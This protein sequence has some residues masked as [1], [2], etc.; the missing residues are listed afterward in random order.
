MPKKVDHTKRKIQIAKAV[1]KVISE[2][3]IEHVTVRKVA[4]TAGLSPGSLRHYFSSQTELLHFSMELVCERV[5]QRIRSRHNKGKTF[6]S[7]IHFICEFLPIDEE[8]SLEL[9]VW[10]LFSAKTRVDDR[11]ETLSKQVY[12]EMHRAFQKVLLKLQS[13]HLVKENLDL[14]LETNRLHHLV[15]GMA[16]HYLLHSEKLTREQMIDTL[17]HHLQS[18]GK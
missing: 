6:E 14:E 18:L 12:E 3:G 15:D 17:R 10:F 11:L 5:K 4:K 13:L 2:K 16:L 1:W 9:E 8:R 7:C